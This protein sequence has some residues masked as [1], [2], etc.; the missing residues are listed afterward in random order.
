[1]YFKIFDYCLK[2]SFLATYK[3]TH[4]LGSVMHATTTASHRKSV[5]WHLC[6]LTATEQI[7][8]NIKTFICLHKNKFN[9]EATSHLKS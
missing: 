3:H 7:F 9:S 8:Q 1:M 5:P 4:F 6:A 2:D